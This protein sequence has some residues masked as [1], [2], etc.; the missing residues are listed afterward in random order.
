LLEDAISR[1]EAKENIAAARLARESLS[2]IAGT[3]S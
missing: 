1:Y 3:R 2:V